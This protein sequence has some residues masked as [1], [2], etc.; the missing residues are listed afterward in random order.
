M[1]HTLEL[2]IGV[3]LII[4]VLWGLERAIHSPRTPIDTS[5]VSREWLQRQGGGR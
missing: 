4:R 2:V 5:H 3:L 1:T